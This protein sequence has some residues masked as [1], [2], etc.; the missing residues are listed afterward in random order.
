MKS[1]PRYTIKVSIGPQTKKT[2]R[3][4]KKNLLATKDFIF[5]QHFSLSL[6]EL[7]K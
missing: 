3:T 1:L 5:T 2:H 6:F 7:G 4:V